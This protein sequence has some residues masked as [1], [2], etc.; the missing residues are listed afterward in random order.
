MLNAKYDVAYKPHIDGLRALAVVS[1]M[2]FHFDFEGFSGGFIGVDVF[3]VISGFLITRIIVNELTTTG[4]FNFKFF[5]WRRA[6]RILPA[7][8]FTIFLSFIFAVLMLSPQHLKNFGGS[9]ISAVFGLSNIFFWEQSSYFD[10]QSINKPLLHSWSLGVKEQF[11]LFWP[12]IIAFVTYK[13]PKIILPILIFIGVVSFALNYVYLS[14]E[15]SSTIFYLVQFRAFEFVI[16]AAMVWLVQL[17]PKHNFIIEILM[18]LGL[19]GVIFS[20]SQYNKDMIFPYYNALLPCISAAFIIYSGSAKYTSKILSNKVS[21]YTGLISYSLYLVHW[22]VFVFYT[23]YKRGDGGVVTFLESA[24]LIPICILMSVI[25][26]NFIEKPF[27]FSWN[28][29]SKATKKSIIFIFFLVTVVVVFLSYHANVN[30]G[31]T[32]RISES[33][34]D[35]MRKNMQEPHGMDILKLN[36]YVWGSE[37]KN[38]LSNINGKK[39]LIIGDSHAGNVANALSETGFSNKNYVSWLIIFASCDIIISDSKVKIPEHS[40]EICKKQHTTLSQLNNL[41]FYDLI[42]LASSWQGQGVMN[43]EETI[44]KLNERGALDK[45]IIIIASKYV[46]NSGLDV[47]GRVNSSNINEG[48]LVLPLEHSVKINNQFIKMGLD[49]NVIYPLKYFCVNDHKCRVL[50]DDGYIL[51]YDEGHLTPKGA[52]FFGERLAADLEYD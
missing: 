15:N 34:K 14:N 40:E 35:L 16:G 8:Y 38:L 39:V 5:Y 2:L 20:V 19:I 1:V 9:L 47:L 51:N 6:R 18:L 24:I 37:H 28:E 36:S 50:D 27:R 4:T 52:A 7:L 26:Y 23:Y 42:I 33:N 49:V 12:A 32:F 25:I 17:Q 30:N 41:K 44:S 10:T 46:T 22:P 43:M 31:W 3:F 48:R 21:V 45:D 11:C 13:T 29:F